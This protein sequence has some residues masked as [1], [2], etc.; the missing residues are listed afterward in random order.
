MLLLM[1]LF[2]Q[3]PNFLPKRE[4]LLFQCVLG[5]VVMKQITLS[6]PT[7]EVL[8]YRVKLE[9]SPDFSIEEDSVKIEPG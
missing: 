3:L 1:S 5:S 7:K 6:N 2:T 4:P 8:A 9:G